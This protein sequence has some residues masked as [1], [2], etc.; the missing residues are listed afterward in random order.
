MLKHSNSIL[1][2]SELM[3]RGKESHI[4]SLRRGRHST[5]NRRTFA[6]KTETSFFGMNCGAADFLKCPLLAV[7]HCSFFLSFT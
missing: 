7:R 3:E 4:A 1:L 5:A 2:N 6:N